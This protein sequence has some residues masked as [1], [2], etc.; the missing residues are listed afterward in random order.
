[1]IKDNKKS[2]I[3]Y[4]S[5]VAGA[6]IRFD[7]VDETDMEVLISEAYAM[8]GIYVDKKNIFNPYIKSNKGSFAVA[9]EIEEERFDAKVKLGEIQ[10]DK[11]KALVGCINPETLV[12]RKVELLGMI[13]KDEVS[14]FNVDEIVAIS[15]AL[16][17]N[18]LTIRW[19]SDLIP[20]DYEEIYLTQLGRMRLFYLDY[21]AEIEEFEKMLGS[22]GYDSSLISDF[23]MTQNLTLGVYEVLNLDNFFNFCNTYDR[24]R[25]ASKKNDNGTGLKKVSKDKK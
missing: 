4:E 19:N 12:L 25:Y 10:G 22:E 11:V 2:E 17:E 8:Y 23:L 24:N 7:K 15:K 1:M 13:N 9:G 3:S 14:K 20:N 16:N 5:L 21:S 18:L 6:L